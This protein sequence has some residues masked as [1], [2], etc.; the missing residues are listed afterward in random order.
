MFRATSR[1]SVGTMTT[2]FHKTIAGRLLAL[3]MLALALAAIVAPVAFAY[4]P[5]PC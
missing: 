1:R 2:K 5:N 3:T 4:P